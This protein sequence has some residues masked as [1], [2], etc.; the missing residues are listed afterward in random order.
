MNIEVCEACA[1]EARRLGIAVEVFQPQT[2]VVY[3]TQGHTMDRL[4]VTSDLAV[5]Q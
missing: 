5:G 4:K 2:H 1:R 3:L